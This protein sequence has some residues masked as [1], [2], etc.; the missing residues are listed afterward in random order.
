M[1]G[2]G[3]QS[4]LLPAH[5]QADDAADGGLLNSLRLKRIKL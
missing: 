5:E 4:V 1:Q 2:R 3:M